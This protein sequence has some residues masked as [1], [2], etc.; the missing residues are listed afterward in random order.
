[1]LDGKKLIA[2][3]KKIGLSKIGLARRMGVSPS[4]VTKAEKDE[5]PGMSLE[6]YENFAKEVRVPLCALAKDTPT[7][8][9]HSPAC[10]STAQ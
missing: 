2:A 7:E 1:M 8:E 10:R 5:Y 6:M 9:G 4:T 3:R